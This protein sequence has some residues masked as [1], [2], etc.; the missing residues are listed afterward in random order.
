ML[1][2]FMLWAEEPKRGGKSERDEQRNTMEKSFNFWDCFEARNLSRRFKL[3]NTVGGNSNFFNNSIKE[4]RENNQKTE[5]ERT[6][7][8]N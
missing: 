4:L 7:Q 2:H 1:C 6:K 8:L 3:W 5:L